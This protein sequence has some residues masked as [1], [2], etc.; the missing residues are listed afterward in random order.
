MNLR[1][2]PR[3]EIESQCVGCG[4]PFFDISLS[5]LHMNGIS[6]QGYGIGNGVFGKMLT[7]GNL[8]TNVS[9]LSVHPL[10]LCRAGFAGDHG[11]WDP[12]AGDSRPGSL[13]GF[14]SGQ[15]L[16]HPREAQ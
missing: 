13:P 1:L 3:S 7:E 14:I 8:S 4:T 10:S 12:D 2:Q 16:L 11:I 9:G 6:R 5:K 15:N